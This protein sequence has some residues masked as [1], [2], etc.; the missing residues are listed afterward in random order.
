MLLPY[1][2]VLPPFSH[3][4]FPH[5]TPDQ[6]NKQKQTNMK[7]KKQKQKSNKLETNNTTKVWNALSME[8]RES[9]SQ[10]LLWSG[11]GQ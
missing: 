11:S 2:I 10:S 4:P 3:A 9:S 5:P 1:S 8:A 6:K 7:D